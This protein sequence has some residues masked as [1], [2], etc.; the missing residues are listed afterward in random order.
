MEGRSVEGWNVG[1]RV[2]GW[3]VKGWRVGGSSMHE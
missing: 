3:S 1:G 2:E